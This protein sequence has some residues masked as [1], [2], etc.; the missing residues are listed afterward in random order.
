[1]GR[2][3]HTAAILRS[4]HIKQHNMQV[5]NLQRLMEKIMQISEGQPKI[6][7]IKYTKSYKYIFNPLSHM[8]CEPTDL[9]RGELLEAADGEVRQQGQHG[10]EEV[11]RPCWNIAHHTGLQQSLDE[12][13]FLWQLNLG[14]VI[15]NGHQ[16]S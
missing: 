15:T 4:D 11:R 5:L 1:M 6:V 7:K 12:R 10:A 13:L 16:P 2:E 14:A 8:I 3:E 9:L